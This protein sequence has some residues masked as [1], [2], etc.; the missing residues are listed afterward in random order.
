M[1]SPEYLSPL[2]PPLRNKNHKWYITVYIYIYT[3]NSE[4]P[5]KPNNHKWYITVYIYIYIYTMNSEQPDKPNNH[6]WY[7]TVYIYIYT[8]NSEQPDKPN[9]HKH[10]NRLEKNPN[11]YINRTA[12]TITHKHMCVKHIYICT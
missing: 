11:C 7:I 4:Q 5:D 1:G 12:T 2:L 3:M 9:N 6:K 8:M 10:F